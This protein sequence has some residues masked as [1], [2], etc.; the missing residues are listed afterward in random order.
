MIWLTAC[1][2]SSI[3]ANVARIVRQACGFLVSRAQILV[4]MASVPSLPQTVRARSST[5]GSSTGPNCTIEPSPST[6]SSPA[7]WLTVT[8]YFSVCGPPAL[9]AT[10]PPMVAV[11]WLD[12]SGAKW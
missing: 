5:A 6:T 8:P 3:E 4:T 12:G 9:V 7:T 11:P 2:A 10:L 1:E